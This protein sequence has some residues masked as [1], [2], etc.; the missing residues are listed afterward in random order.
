MKAMRITLRNIRCAWSEI[1][2]DR[3]AMDMVLCIVTLTL[4][5]FTF[6][7]WMWIVSWMA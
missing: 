1:K 5:T 2:A 3:S 7:A 4:F 6:W